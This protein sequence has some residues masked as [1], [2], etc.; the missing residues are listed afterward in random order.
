MRFIAL[1]KPIVVTTAIFA[2]IWQVGPRQP[3]PIP[4]F[5]DLNALSPVGA[6]A[7]QSIHCPG[8][9]RLN[10]REAVVITDRLYHDAAALDARMTAVGLDRACADA[11][12][13][14]KSIAGD[15]AETTVPASPSRHSSLQR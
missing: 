15:N 11:L 14:A 9:K 2:A 10:G 1:A 6:L 8:P 7:W 13:R 3:A 5:D 4:A 12:N